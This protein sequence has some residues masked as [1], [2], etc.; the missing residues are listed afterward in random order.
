MTKKNNEYRMR[1]EY[2]HI[3]IVDMKT[4]NFKEIDKTV[5]AVKKKFEG[6]K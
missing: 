5:K 6:C 2:E 3:P 4:N 1:I